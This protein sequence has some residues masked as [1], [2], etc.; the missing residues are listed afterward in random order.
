MQKIYIKENKM[1][2]IDMNS[3]NAVI[4]YRENGLNEYFR[5]ILL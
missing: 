1:K 3:Y 5:S 2:H 4:F